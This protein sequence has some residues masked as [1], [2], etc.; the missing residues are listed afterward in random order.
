MT[1]S[2]VS[3]YSWCIREFHQGFF[4]EAVL[5]NNHTQITVAYFVDSC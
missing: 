1:C 3:L 4:H 5:L 2:L